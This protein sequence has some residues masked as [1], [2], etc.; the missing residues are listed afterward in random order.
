MVFI[1]ELYE[2]LGVSIR[3][4]NVRKCLTPYFIGELTEDILETMYKNMEFNWDIDHIIYFIDNMLSL[5]D[6]E[7]LKSIR[8]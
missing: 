8:G 1:E 7:R 2:A 5:E 3:I 4:E 6:L